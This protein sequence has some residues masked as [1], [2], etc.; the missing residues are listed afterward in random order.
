M[1]TNVRVPNSSTQTAAT[2]LAN[3]T[4]ISPNFVSALCP[5]YPFLM[6]PQPLTLNPNP[7]PRSKTVR[8]HPEGAHNAELP[9]PRQA[10]HLKNPKRPKNTK[11]TKTATLDPKPTDVRR[12]RGMQI[13]GLRLS[14]QTF[15]QKTK[16]LSALDPKPP[17]QHTY[18]LQKIP[19]MGALII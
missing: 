7:N 6:D 3:H 19:N 10:E 9:N 13:L 14:T 1:K 4:N 5:G 17:P 15:N 12:V 11:Q 16:S 2:P 8:T 18:L